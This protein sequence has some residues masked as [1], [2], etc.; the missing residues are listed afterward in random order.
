MNFYTLSAMAPEAATPATT[1]RAV[2]VGPVTLPELVDR[3]QLVIRVAS[4]RVEI[5]ETDRWAE[6]LKSEIPRLLAEN[7]FRLLRPARV[8]TIDQSESRD[9][10]YRVLVDIQRFES[11]PGEGVM[12][13][14]LW[15]VRRSAAGA[16]PRRGSS[17]V[18]ERAV[19]AGYDVLVAAHGRALAAISSDIAKALREE[20][21]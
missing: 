5:V 4:D 13:D 21:L 7:L 15:S 8:S 14:A 18:R 1:L 16:T 11:I 2:A 19:G 17:Q 20:G 10:E 3:P 6:P 12:I 9:A